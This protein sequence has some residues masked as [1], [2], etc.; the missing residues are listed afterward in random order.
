MIRDFDN[1]L[2][3]L[4]VYPIQDGY[5]HPSE[6]ILLNCFSTDIGIT[7][8][9]CEQISK[10]NVDFIKLI[11]RLPSNFLNRILIFENIEKLLK[12][13]NNNDVLDSIIQL[14]ESIE[15]PV[16]EQLLCRFISRAEFDGGISR[17]LLKY[18]RE[19]LDDIVN[20]N[21]RRKIW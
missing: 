14:L 3:L 11:G 6:E 21:I 4:K 18:A 15:H 1:I 17:W 9:I 5:T 19:V 13:S 2:N 12:I 7:D 20:K 10:E 8:F 16:C